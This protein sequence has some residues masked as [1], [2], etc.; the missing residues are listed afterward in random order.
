MAG[1]DVHVQSMYHSV[2]HTARGWSGRRKLIVNRS[3]HAIQLV[4]FTVR[5][6]LFPLM[7]NPDPDPRYSVFVWLP[8]GTFGNWGKEVVLICHLARQSMCQLPTLTTGGESG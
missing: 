7:L 6:D 2:V 4:C 3:H 1:V 5:D 8:L